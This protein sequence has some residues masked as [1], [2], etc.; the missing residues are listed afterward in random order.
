M[1][2]LAAQGK[3]VAEVVSFRHRRAKRRPISCCQKEEE[4]RREEEEWKTLGKVNGYG[5]GR[6]ETF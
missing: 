3:E 2:V 1:A 6:R 4:R 5:S